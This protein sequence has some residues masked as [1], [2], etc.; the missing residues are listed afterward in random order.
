MVNGTFARLGWAFAG[1]VGQAAMPQL[2]AARRERDA[3]RR[4]AGDAE[5]VRAGQQIVELR[6]AAEE[7]AAPRCRA[8][9]RGARPAPPGARP[10]AETSAPARIVRI[11]GER[12]DGLNESWSS[13]A[14]TIRLVAGARNE[15]AHGTRRVSLPVGAITIEPV[16]SAASGGVGLV[17]VTLT[18]RVSPTPRVNWY[19]ATVKRSAPEL[20][21][22]TELSD[23]ASGRVETF[24]TTIVCVAFQRGPVYG[25]SA[26]AVG[27]ATISPTA[28]APRSRLPLPL[29]VI[30]AP[31]SAYPVSRLA[32]AEPSSAGRI[33]MSS[34]AAPA[35]VAAAP[36][37]PLTVP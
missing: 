16:T 20:P 17:T 4:A 23:S 21:F 7:V 1:S 2:V 27:D 12:S 8:A 10:P 28:L 26:S 30:A 11:A 25:P 34:A 19:G 32:M 36:L 9:G 3:R 37:V 24:R 5:A 6:E 33:W 13:D 15:T 22:A 29:A 18:F 31:G 35:T 14:F